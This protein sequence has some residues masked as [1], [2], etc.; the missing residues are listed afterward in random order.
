VPVTHVTLGRILEAGET[1]LSRTFLA[2]LHQD[3][4]NPGGLGAFSIAGGDT[5]KFW[6]APRRDM[7]QR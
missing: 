2:R 1:P 4:D 3:L 6:S 7:G 5:R